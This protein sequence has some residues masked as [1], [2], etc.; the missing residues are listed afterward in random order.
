MLGDAIRGEADLES[1]RTILCCQVVDKILN[2][3]DDLNDQSGCGRRRRITTERLLHVGRC[4]EDGGA[5]QF[6]SV[7]DQTFE[8]PRQVV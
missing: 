3:I 8:K 4:V 7:P 6:G 5:G 1:R 2:R